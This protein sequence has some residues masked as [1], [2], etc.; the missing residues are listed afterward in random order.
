MPLTL[1]SNSLAFASSTSGTV[2]EKNPWKFIEKLTASGDTSLD[3]TNSAISNHKSLFIYFDGLDQS[4]QTNTLMNMYLDGSL[5]QQSYHS[6]SMLTMTGSNRNG[7]GS[8]SM[9]YWQIGGENY[10]WYHNIT[11]GMYISGVESGSYKS[12]KSELSGGTANAA[13][14]MS[15]A[16]FYNQTSSKITGVQIRPS[17]GTFLSGAVHLYGLNEHD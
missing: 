16:G 10:T 9:T 14:N 13:Q 5:N 15:A 17:S 8:G 2:E 1:N 4:N 3:F 12:F 7:S 11:G 6:N